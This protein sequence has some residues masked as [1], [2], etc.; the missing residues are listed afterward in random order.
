MSPTGVY[1]FEESPDDLSWMPLA[2]RRAADVA[3]RKPSL[4]AWQSLSF[5]GRRAL[6]SLGQER[7]IDVVEVHR[8]LDRAAPL[9]PQVAPRAEP[10]PL[11][12]TESLRTAL[13]AGRA[14]P[15][16]VWSALSALDRYA[17]VKVAE[18]RREKLGAAYDEIVGRSAEVSHVDAGGAARMVG[19]SEKQA[20]VRRAVATSRVTMNAEA[21]ERLQKANAPK[22]DVLGTARLAGIQGVKRTSDLIP[23]CHPIAVTRVDVRLELDSQ[24]L[25]VDITVAVEAFD[26]T[27]VEMEALAGAST[28]ALTVYDMLKAFDRSMTIGPTALEAKSGGR[29]GDY[30]RSRSQPSTLT[31]RFALREEPLSIEEALRLVS[32]PEAGGSVV[33][34]GSV[35][36]HN[37]EGPVQ[38]LE[39]QAY[40][41]MAVKELARVAREIEAEIPGVR[42]AALHR[43]GAL[44]VGDVAVVCAASAA[45][46]DEAFRAAR[47]LIDRLKQRVP[48]WKRE[49]GADGPHWVGWQ[50]ARD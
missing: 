23:L 7:E 24:A 28:A 13:G 48:I 37:S 35:R 47:L 31:D 36:D 19:I 10:T 2:A 21:F 18:S 42:L 29:S 43:S 40:P 49:H 1:A 32:R 14:L 25:A 5:E 12:A 11:N 9:P 50:D 26:R 44:R 15:D 46:R 30:A 4:I 45:H 16:S 34:V 3:G 17:L 22:G 20:S 41:E 39:Y 33:F 38:L 6:V 8:W 27:G